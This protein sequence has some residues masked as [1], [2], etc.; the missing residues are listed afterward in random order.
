[1]FFEQAKSI[2]REQI[3]IKIPLKIIIDF[4]IIRFFYSKSFLTFLEIGNYSHSSDRYDEIKIPKKNRLVEVIKLKI[5][6]KFISFVVIIFK[7]C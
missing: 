7:N 4:S 2:K 1:M 6:I 5:Q 3:K